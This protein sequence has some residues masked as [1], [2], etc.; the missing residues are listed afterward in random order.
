MERFGDDS[1]R[2]VITE[3]KDIHTLCI[4]IETGEG[5][6]VGNVS[7]H[8]DNDA[9]LCLAT[10]LKKAYAELK[11]LRESFQ[12]VGFGFYRKKKAPD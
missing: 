3:P 12:P 7:I 10:K 11:E 2:V 9:S 1:D 8:T 4:D 6:F 5:V